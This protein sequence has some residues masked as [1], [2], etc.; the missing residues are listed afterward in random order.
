MDEQEAREALINFIRHNDDDWFDV[1]PA[2]TAKFYNL[3]EAAITEAY[4]RGWADG[5]D[6][7]YMDERYW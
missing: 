6:D 4:D 5:K 1:L 3:L 2:A 7:A